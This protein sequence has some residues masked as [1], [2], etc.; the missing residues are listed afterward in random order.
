MRAVDTGVAPAPPPDGVV[1]ETWELAAVGPTWLPDPGESAVSPVSGTLEVHTD[2][3]VFRATDAIDAGTG[4]PL[5]AIIP[6]SAMRA[7]GPLSPGDPVAG[8]WMPRWQRRLRSP[9]FVVGTDAGAWVFD[10]PDGPK[11]ARL[12]SERFGVT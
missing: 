3:L 4:A 5:V 7:I 8:H 10:G 12:L 2:A 6:A 11:R 9:G 1:L